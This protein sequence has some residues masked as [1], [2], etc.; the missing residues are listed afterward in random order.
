MKEVKYVYDTL[1]EIF[2]RMMKDI[3]FYISEGV[4]QDHTIYITRNKRF[5]LIVKIAWS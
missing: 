4:Y 3:P 2:Y 1:E 5:L